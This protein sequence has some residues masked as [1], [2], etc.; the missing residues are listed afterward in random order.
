MD[1]LSDNA[2]AVLQYATQL[3]WVGAE[4]A[5][6]GVASPGEGNMNRTLRLRLNERSIIL[7]QSVAWVAKYPHIAAPAERIVVERRFY[8]AISD[9]PALAAHV[10]EVLGFD[11]IERV[12][13]LED[14]GELGDMTDLYTQAAAAVDPDPIVEW[15]SAL[16]ALPRNDNDNDDDDRAFSNRAMR[17]LNH[18]HI[19][20]IPLQPDNGVVLEPVLAA[21]A[22]QFAADEPLCARAHALGAIYLGRSAHRSPTV[23]LHG[24][25]YPGSWLRHPE[26]QV[27]IIDPEFAFEGPAEFDV[28]VFIA[29]LFM[30][31]IV[32]KIAGGFANADLR[33]TLRRYRAPQNFD[34]TLCMAFTAMEVIRRLLGVAQLPLQTSTE[35]R[36]AWLADARTLIMATGA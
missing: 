17:E 19:F 18:A 10:P 3:G 34:Q 11:P 14:L 2:A 20:D 13:C 16:H 35:T 1:L 22:A 5:L 25:F 33:R 30:A 4:E 29:H 32:D 7:K 8:E 15:L 31:G 27:M 6:L 23:L 12:L 21:R 24:D 9:T 36:A 28:G 26:R